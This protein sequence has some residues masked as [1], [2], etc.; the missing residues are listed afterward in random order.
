MFKPFKT[1]EEQCKEF[2]KLA[3]EKLKNGPMTIELKELESFFSYNA[4]HYESTWIPKDIRDALR[5]DNIIL[6]KPRGR[7]YIIIKLI[8]STGDVVNSQ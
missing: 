2:K 8:E 4:A 1:I 6:K 3:Q 7:N 5:K